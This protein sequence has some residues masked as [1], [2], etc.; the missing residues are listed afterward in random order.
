V[1]VRIVDDGIGF[2]VAG[3]PAQRFGLLGMSERARLLGGEL[4][5]T[6]TPDAG[7]IV[8]VDVPLHRRV[9]LAAEDAAPQLT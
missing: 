7:T 4:R 6:S 9:A 5:I 2:D 1:R 8:D 3:L